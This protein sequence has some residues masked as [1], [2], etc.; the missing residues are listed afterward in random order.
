M[1]THTS[2]PILRVPSKKPIPWPACGERKEVTERWRSKGVFMPF[3]A[4]HFLPQKATI[5]SMNK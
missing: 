2:H 5:F 1:E 4:L 3:Y